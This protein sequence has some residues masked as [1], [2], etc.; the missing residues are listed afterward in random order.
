MTFGFRN[1]LVNTLVPVPL[2]TSEEPLVFLE[3]CFGIMVNRK[4]ED[5]SCAVTPV[6]FCEQKWVTCLSH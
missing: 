5:G 2:L 3:F 4:G 1:V 6:A